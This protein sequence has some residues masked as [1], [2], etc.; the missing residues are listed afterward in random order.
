MLRHADIADH[1][2]WVEPA[3]RSITEDFHPANVRVECQLGRAHF[4][5]GS[6]DREFVV[7]KGQSDPY[8]NVSYLLIWLAWSKSGNAAERH[9]DEIKRIAR[10]AG[11]HW[12]EFH[13]HRQGFERIAPRLGMHRHATIYR[14]AV[15]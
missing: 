6:N 5:L 14:G 9:I 8:S 10:D 12:I 15:E 11:F 1:W 4:L 13:T 3:I 7:L 2:D